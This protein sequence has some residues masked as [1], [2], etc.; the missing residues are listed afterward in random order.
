M[1]G[2]T[3]ARRAWSDV[4][5]LGGSQ[6][7]LVALSGGALIVTARALGPDGYGR[8]ALV[9]GLSSLGSTIAFSWTNAAVTRFGAEALA[10]G[11]TAGEVFW[12]RLLISLASLALLVAAL[13]VAWDGVAAFTGAPPGTFGIA[14][15]LVATAGLSAHAVAALQGSGRMRALA[16][17]RLVERAVYLAIVA[18]PFLG[19]WPLE[20]GL[21]LIAT[22][23]GRALSA[24]ATFGALP[25]AAWLPISVD[26]RTA[27]LILAYSAPTLLSF[28]SGYVFDWADAAILR[29]WLGFDAVG[30]Y[31]AGYQGMLFVS[32]LLSA[33]STIAFPTLV[34]F[35]SS[36]RDD[37]TRL[38]LDRLVPL[39]VGAWS[40]GVA[41]LISI[42]PVV[43]PALLGS[44]MSMADL[45]LRVLLVGTA[46]EC[47]T[48]LSTAVASSYDQTGRAAGAHVVMTVMNVVLDL[49]LVPVVGVVGPAIATAAAYTTGALLY[50]LFTR[51]GLGLAARPALLAAA[52][53]APLALAA[54]LAISDAYVRLGVVAAMVAI[55]LVW[56]RRAHVVAPA[57]LGLLG[58]LGVPPAAL[59]IVA[60]AL[61]PTE[62][63]V[64]VHR[65]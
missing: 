16:A 29:A 42:S 22:V 40:V 1:I 39:V 31:Q 10:R 48:A 11:R 57:D 17:S 15:A 54:S 21:V 5:A 62:R 64:A 65:S 35:R 43:V 19:G 26:R 36:G 8:V 25:A 46:F 14:V 18:V 38:Y 55:G 27:G 59:A 30:S 44:S 47:V 13:A 34:A 56:V 51:R 60:R 23:A 3:A 37:L 4:L 6:L 28:G 24:M 58:R 32:A 20:L 63:A 9:L 12:T 52:L 7:A 33:L 41:V 53:P 50:H 61:A 2:A 45:V 49:A